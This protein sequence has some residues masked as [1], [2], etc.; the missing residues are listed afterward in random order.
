M[1]TTSALRARVAGSSSAA[2]IDDVIAAILVARFNGRSIQELCAMGGITL[3]DFTQSVA[4]REIFGRGEAR[5]VALG[6]ARGEARGE[7]KV[8]LRQLSRRCGPLSAEQES[9][10]RSLPL[11]RLEALAEALLDFEG[12][13]DLNAWLAANT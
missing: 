9:V 6:E 13:A 7:A 1:A 8:T 2:E 11:E 3:D 12:M 10:I 5:G 4:Y